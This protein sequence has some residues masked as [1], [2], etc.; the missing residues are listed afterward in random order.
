MKTLLTSVLALVLMQLGAQSLPSMKMPSSERLAG[1][2]PLLY[3]IPKTAEEYTIV[4]P[5]LLA[6]IQWLADTP[7]DENPSKREDQYKYLLGWITGSPT[8][9]MDL[10]P[11]VADMSQKNPEVIIYYSAGWIDYAVRN[12]YSTDKMALHSA[13]IRYVLALYDKGYMKKDKMLSKL[14]KVVKKD[15]LD[16][17]VQEQLDEQVANADK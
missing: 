3:Q 5:N 6:T 17:W 11:Y 15:K 8:V 12:D 10:F 13:A 16:A 9:N 7:P 4:E 2:A 14:A 1:I